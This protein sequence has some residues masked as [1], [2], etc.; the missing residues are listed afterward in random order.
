MAN[1]RAIARALK[2]TQATVSLALRDSPSIPEATRERVRAEAA[3]QGYRPSPL[4]TTLMEHI[5][6]GKPVRDR[7]CIALLVDA[8]NEKDWMQVNFDTYHRQLEGYRHQAKLRGYRTEAFYLRAKNASPDA[9]DRQLHARGISGVIL[10]APKRPSAT[11]PQIRWER[12]ALA[13]ISYTWDRPLIDRVSSHHRH[14]I[15]F[16][17][18]EVRRRGYRRVGLCIPRLAVSG[19]DSNWTAGYLV[20]Q[21][22]LP[23]SQRLPLFVGTVHDTSVDEFRDWLAR[24]RPDA[25]LTLLGE[26]VE[27]MHTLS[28]GFDKLGVVCLNLSSSSTLSGIDEN[29]RVVGATACDIVV[30]Q[31]THN[32]RGLPA[33]PKEILIEGTWREGVSLPGK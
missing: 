9:T 17:F 3:R 12:Y 10:T 30:N 23:S 31:I 14:N 19:V 25:I 26:E 28:I 32:E 21:S 22:V 27:W 6:S 20:A 33:Y 5:R 8:A 16:A 24:H 7:G 13:T 4:V 18:A 2:L 1:Q 15:D 29:N 11:T